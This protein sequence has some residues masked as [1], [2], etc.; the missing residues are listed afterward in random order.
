MRESRT[1]GSEGGEAGNTVFPTPYRRAGFPTHHKALAA[2]TAALPVVPR[3]PV[4][5]FVRVEQ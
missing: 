2:Q 4:H 3:D 1:Y 5:R